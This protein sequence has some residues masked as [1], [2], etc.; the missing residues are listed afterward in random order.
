MNPPLIELVSQIYSRLPGTEQTTSMPILFIITGLPGTGKSY[1]ARKIAERLPAVIV[2]SDFV[3]KFI[4]PKPTYSSEE[5]ALVHQVARS[6]TERLL[7]TGCRVI[8]DATNLVEWHREKLYH[9][10][11]KTGVRLVIIQTVASED[12]I[13][14]RLRQRHRTR[15]PQ[16]MSDADWDVVELLK[17]EQQP[18]QRPYIV[19]DASD[20]FESALEKILREAM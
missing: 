9:V 8:Y 15:D 1:L 16:D 4:S 7:V 13:R 6:L 10:A 12:V 17:P 19:V 2:Q 18:I 3:R 5:S 11:E 14:T 20:D